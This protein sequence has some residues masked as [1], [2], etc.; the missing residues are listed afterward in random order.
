MME[1]K[2]MRKGKRAAGQLRR[3]SAADTL[4]LLALLLVVAGVLVRAFVN[5]DNSEESAS[6]G[7]YDVYFTVEEI[8]TTVLSDIH[9]FDA[10]YDLE[11]G[12]YMGSIGVYEDGSAAITQSG[13]LPA[14][15]GELV[16]AQG[17]MVCLEGT[18]NDGALLPT[19][20]T[21][22]LAPGSVVTLRTERA[23]LTVEITEIVPRK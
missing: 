13:I 20:A 23:V 18:L 19:G 1:G 11:T 12:V 4:I 7:P 17:C 22:Y 6:S 9:G 3:W 2:D 15:G 5:V 8:R 14:E 21:R 10:L 16:T